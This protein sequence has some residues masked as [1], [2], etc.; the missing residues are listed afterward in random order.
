MNEQQAVKFAEQKIAFSIDELKRLIYAAKNMNDLIQ[1]KRYLC[2]YFIPCSKPHG[3]FMWRPDIKNLE[4]IPDNNIGK[5]IKPITK[6]FY[7]QSKQGSSY[8]TEF[9]INKW[10]MNEYSSVCVAICDPKKSRIFKVNGQLYLN[11]FPGFSHALQPLSDFEN[12]THLA[13]KFIFSHIRD[14]W[15]SGN[16]DLTEYIIKWLAGM[17]AGRKMYSI[18]YL[19][20]GQGWGKGIITDFIQRHVLG[21]QLVYKTSDP[22]TILGSF[23]GQLMSKL[24]LL[25]EE[26]PTE[27]SQWN[28]LYRALKD[29]VTSNTIEIHEKYKTPTQYENFMS[30]IVLTNENALRVENDDRRTVFLDVSPI[31]KGNLE[32]FKKLGNAMKYP[33]VSEAF[34]AYLRVIADAHPD[35]NG[36]PPPMT[37]SKQEH[38][39]STLPPLF[40]FIKDSYLISGNIIYDL[41]IQEFYNAYVSSCDIHHITPLSKINVARILSNELDINS[42]RVYIDGKQTRVL[43]ITREELYQ[44]YVAKNW[45]HE[46]D[47][48]DIDGVEDVP[49]NRPTADL[50]ALDR[51]LAEIRGTPVNAEP[52]K[53]TKT[54]I[55][56]SSP[57]KLKCKVVPEKSSKKPPVPLKPDHLKT[58]STIEE[59]SVAI[60]EETV[61]EN[62][63][64]DFLECLLSCEP[65]PS[66][67]SPIKSEPPVKPE[68]SA[69]ETAKK[70]TIEPLAQD[71]QP[72]EGTQ[73][74]WNWLE[75]HR[76]DNK[77]WVKKTRDEAFIDLFNKGKEYWAKY[78]NESDEYD[79]EI[80][81]EEVKELDK[82]RHKTNLYSWHMIKAINHFKDWVKYTKD[83]PVG[84]LVTGKELVKILE[85]YQENK[86]AEIIPVP[87]GYQTMKLDKG[88]AVEPR[89]EDHEMEREWEK[90]NGII[91]EF[92]DEGFENICEDL[93]TF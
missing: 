23:N 39:I 52:L 29:K 71:P 81:I 61:T 87:S 24:L 60:T 15:C 41:S 4:H 75:R 59:K 33:G 54:V 32:Y 77:P 19:K 46:M 76:W 86:N 82:I 84:K 50:N 68:P 64:N 25:L 69:P 56:Q 89:R 78:I 22:Q 74:Y 11:I 3:I 93:G 6:V 49:Q 43:N 48:I 83:L 66:N 37:T 55:Q 31:Q 18:L 85:A 38:I 90:A 5:L 63:V 21:T 16:W 9:S 70:N 26:M 28:S 1:A 44:K 13:V 47:E 53:V 34:Y 35:F 36:N 45:I 57:Q 92:D 30:T 65:G 72:K 79:W 67:S 27:K 17:A 58:K 62:D 51:F 42:N 80:L 10:F 12:K 7:I 88:K 91:D 73:A 14:V 8:K 40:Q 20:S 2:S